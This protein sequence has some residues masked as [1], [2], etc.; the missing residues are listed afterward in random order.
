[1]STTDRDNDRLPAR[2]LETARRER[3]EVILPGRDLTPPFWERMRSYSRRKLF[4]ARTK[5]VEAFTELTHALNIQEQAAH[6]LERTRLRSAEWDEETERKRIRTNYALEDIDLDEAL[7]QRQHEQELARRRREAELNPPEPPQTNH[8][9][10]REEQLR[11]LAD[12]VLQ[13]GTTGRASK[14]AEQKIADFIASRGGEE[15]LSD[16]DRE[17]IAQ[18]RAEALRLDQS[19]GS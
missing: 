16:E 13:Y 1:M 5:E 7:E 12:D 9:P 15:S 2:R 8:G 4:E 17:N 11:N 6:S 3:T 18:L 10:T 14:V 19:K